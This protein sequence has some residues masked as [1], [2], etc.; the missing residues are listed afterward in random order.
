MI[1]SLLSLAGLT[2]RNAP[3][4]ARW[5]PTQPGFPRSEQKSRLLLAAKS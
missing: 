1:H 5:L 2:R 3:Q 4:Q